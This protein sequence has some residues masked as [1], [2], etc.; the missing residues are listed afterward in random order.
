MDWLRG[1]KS[2]ATNLK[3]EAASLNRSTTPTP[4]N[5]DGKPNFRSGLLTIRV[6]WA[7]GLGLPD[8]VAVPAVIQAALAS[9]QA[10]VAASV[11]PS[12][13]TQQRLAHKSRGNRFVFVILDSTQGSVGMTEIAS[14][15]SSAGGYHTLSWNTRSIKSSSLRWVA[16]LT[17]RSTCIK[18]HCMLFSRRRRRDIDA[19]RSDVSRNSEISLQLYLRADEPKRGADGMADDLGNDFFLGGT[20]FVPN[21]DEMGNQDQW[22]DI[23][24]GSGRIQIGVAYKPSFGHSLT[25]DDFELITVIGKGSFGKVSFIWVRLTVDLIW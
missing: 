5:P 14:S 25:I 3:A 1:K 7:E 11:S 12:S 18:L 21:F 10:K 24:G 8:G 9:Q 23:V 15:A 13:V 16:T 2:S 22:Y 6:L 19:A 4:R 17:S 20:K